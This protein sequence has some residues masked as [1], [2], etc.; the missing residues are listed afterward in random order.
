MYLLTRMRNNKSCCPKCQRPSIVFILS[1][2]VFLDTRPT[3]KV[4]GI[5]HSMSYIYQA[6][7]QKEVWTADFRGR[8][9]LFHLP[10]RLWLPLLSPVCSLLSADAL[11]ALLGADWIRVWRWHQ[12]GQTFLPREH[13]AARV[14][15]WLGE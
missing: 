3:R 2:M 14:N 10:F 7:L 5:I 6:V 8:K 4:I 11:G 12:G 13:R 1:R 15:S 9:C